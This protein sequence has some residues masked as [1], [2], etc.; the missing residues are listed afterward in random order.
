MMRR[1]RIKEVV[2]I[3]INVSESVAK[4]HGIVVSAIIIWMKWRK[5]PKPVKRIKWWKLKDLKVKNK[6]K[7]EVIE[8]GILGGQENWQ[9]VAEMIRSIARMELSESLGK[10]STAGRW[11]TWWWWYQ[12]VQERLKDKRKAKK[13]WDTIR[14]DA[15]KLVYKTARKQAK[16][17]VAKAKNKVYEE[18]YEKMETKEGKNE[19]FKIAKQRNRQSKDVQ[20][21]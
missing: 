7:M 2:Y 1:G 16:R 19:L 12:E 6:F 4:Q 15:S 5:A 21:E 3:K 8:S 9:R 11:E 10:I 17:E 18:L 13:V 20:Q 14:D